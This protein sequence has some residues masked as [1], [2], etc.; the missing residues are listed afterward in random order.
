M[1]AFAAAQRLPSLAD[2]KLSLSLSNPEIHVAVDRKRAA[3]LGVRM[4]TIGSALRLA[5]AGD[6]EIS[7]YREGGEQYP[8]KIRVLES[9]RRDL[10]AIGRITV[11]SAS[12]APVRIDNLAKLERGLGPSQLQRASRRF[13]FGSSP[14]HP[15]RALDE[16]SNDVRKLLAD[17]KLHDMSFS[18]QRPDENSRRTRTCHGR[19]L[20]V[21]FVL[22]C[23]RR[24]RASCSRSSSCWRCHCRCRSL[25]TLWATTALNLW[26]ALGCCCCWGS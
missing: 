8:V 9:Q 5:V 23:W 2:P 22:W 3:D 26:S 15:G 4:A 11:P 1:K 25:F 12:G 20:A 24:V 10:A 6:D 14:T 17:L 19:S 7:T 21:I 18:T 16:A 13:S